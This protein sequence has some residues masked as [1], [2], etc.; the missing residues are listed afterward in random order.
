MIE[1]FRDF[2]SDC[3]ATIRPWNGGFK[4][5]IKTCRGKV[6]RNQVFPTHRGAVRAMNNDSDGCM[7]RVDDRGFL[8]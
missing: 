2:N 6:L 5:V 7:E 1:R 8:L 3:T 4:L